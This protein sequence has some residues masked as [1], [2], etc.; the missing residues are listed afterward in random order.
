MNAFQL[1]NYI[2]NR[3][4]Q[5]SARVP[6]MFKRP[7]TRFCTFS[8]R[9]THQTDAEQQQEEEAATTT[10]A[11]AN[12]VYKHNNES[13]HNYYCRINGAIH[14]IILFFL[15]TFCSLSL[16]HSRRMVFLMCFFVCYIQICSDSMFIR[17]AS[18]V[19]K[20]KQ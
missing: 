7:F 8:I 3:I 6:F 13:A 16:L 20:M 5:S 17:C 12:L 10:D 18:S 1:E 9:Q 4:A 14:F 19:C 11:N 15:H 2:V